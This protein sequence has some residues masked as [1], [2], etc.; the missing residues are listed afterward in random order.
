MRQQNRKFVDHS[1]TQSRLTRYPQVNDRIAF[2]GAGVSSLH[3]AH[4]L[5][6]RGFRNMT[7]LE[8]S[9]RHGGKSV[10]IPHLKHPEVKHD[11]GTVYLHEAYDVVRD[12]ANELGVG[13][14]VSQEGLKLTR[15][16]SDSDPVIQKHKG[17]WMNMRKWILA[18][19]EEM[20]LGKVGAFVPDK[21]QVV[22]VFSAYLRYKKIHKKTMSEYCSDDPRNGGYPL[23]ALHGL[24][25]L[26]PQPTPRHWKKHLSMTFGEFLRKNNCQALIPIIAYMTT[27]QGY[28]G[29]EFVPA[30]Y[31]LSWLTPK[32]IL[33]VLKKKPKSLFLHGYGAIWDKIV[34]QD[35][36]DIRY[37]VQIQSIRRQ[38][39]EN[40]EVI[41]KGTNRDGSELNESFDWL[42]LGAPLKH[43]AAYMEDLDAEENEIFQSLTNYRF[44]AA[45]ISRDPESTRASAH[46]DILIDTI[47][48]PNKIGQGEVMGFRD[49]YV[50]YKKDIGDSRD[51]PREQIFYQFIGNLPEHQAITEED[52]DQKMNDYFKKY[53]ITGAKI[54]QKGDPNVPEGG[55]WEYF[56]QFTQK[57]L[58]EGKPWRLLQRQGQNSTFYVHASTR[59]ESVLD[60]IMYT[61]ALFHRIIEPNIHK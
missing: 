53:N 46:A 26:P 15:L 24:S 33:G 27:A 12:L 47:F 39:G 52:L 42:F 4:L 43:C 1:K 16:Y 3:M 19:T 20:S 51:D 57:D 23:T 48:D 38:H 45:L 25:G 6:K 5:H 10:T 61:T 7:I 54:I 14:E 31:G 41:I 59:F 60:V 34:E 21:L 11:I 49:S 36:L 37:G 29:P 2:V 9:H 18:K 40:Q 28:G 55:A 32:V 50:V 22:P 30:F 17:D 13:E 44:R 35:Q 8:K 56:Y 58:E